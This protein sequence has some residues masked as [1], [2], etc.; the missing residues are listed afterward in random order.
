MKGE[1]G[2]I[3]ELS[4]IFGKP[5]G[6]VIC[7][8]GDDTAVIAPDSEDYL[9]WTIDSLIEGV[10]FDLTYTP[11]KQLGRKALAVNLSDIAAMGG[12]PQYSLLALGWPPERELTGSSG[13]GPGDAGDG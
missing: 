2:L 4:Q 10:H 5:P 7:G 9:L 3:A 1:R 6:Q 11:L 13:P 12:E 8:I